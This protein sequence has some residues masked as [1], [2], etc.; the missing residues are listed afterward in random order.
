MLGDR[1]VSRLTTIII[2]VTVS[3]IVTL[4]FAVEHYRD[5]ATIYMKQRD[6]KTHAL[7]M[8]N[9]TITDMLQ[10]QRDVAVLDAK[11]TKE[12]NDAKAENA[13]L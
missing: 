4:G 9:D 10:R 1:P 8:A 6:E 2:T 12:L 13:V 7:N 11:Y 3:I 5:N